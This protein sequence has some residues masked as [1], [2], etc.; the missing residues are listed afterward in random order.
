MTD[1]ITKVYKVGSCPA[2]QADITCRAVLEIE[3]TPGGY[4]PDP[5]QEGKVNLQAKLTGA[6]A[7]PHDCTKKVTR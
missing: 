5:R 3:P 1:T 6:T 2:C 7:N 4:A